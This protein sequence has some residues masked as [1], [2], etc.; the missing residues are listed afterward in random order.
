[1]SNMNEQDFHKAE[2]RKQKEVMKTNKA[3]QWEKFS[4]LKDRVP[5]GRAPEC[6]AQKTHTKAHHYVVAQRKR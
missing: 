2:E 4:E 1:M 3:M 5:G 6:P